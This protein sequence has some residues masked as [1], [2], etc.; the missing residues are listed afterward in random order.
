[1]YHPL[2]A[3]RS[4]IGF[5]Q[6]TEVVELANKNFAAIFGDR[7]ASHGAGT[8]GIFNR[9]LGPDQASSDPGDY[10]VDPGAIGWP[11]DN[12]YLHSFHVVDPAASGHVG[13]PSSGAYRSPASLP[14]GQLLVSY[15]ANATDLANFTGNFDVYLMDPLTGQKTQLTSDAASDELSAVAVYQRA[16]R[17]VFASR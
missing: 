1:D 7:G 14:S 17:G 13:A 9:S 16:D 5:Q 11:I 8:L 12:F 6:M 4:S 2:F 15:A 10:T 3:Q